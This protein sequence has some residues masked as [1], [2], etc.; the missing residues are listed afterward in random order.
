MGCLQIAGDDKPNKPEPSS[1]SSETIQL[2]LLMLGDSAVGKTSLILRYCENTFTDTFI[3]SLTEEYKEKKV[4]VDG[5]TC[6]IQIYDTAG[7]ERFRK[8]TSSYFRGGQGVMLC[9]DLTKKTTF[10]NLS[11]WMQEI[12][13]Y[14]D[15]GVSIVLVGNK[16]DLGVAEVTS[17]DIEQFIRENHLEYFETSAKD[18]SGVEDAFLKLATKTKEACSEEAN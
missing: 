6:E 7:Q 17:N 10:E 5:K 13:K 14:G 12:K 18:G 16:K 3:G 1:N 11:K 8:V 2:K 15:D 4:T 9:F